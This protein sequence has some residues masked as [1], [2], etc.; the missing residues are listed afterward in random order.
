V[1]EPGKNAVT[2]VGRL[3]CSTNQY[4]HEDILLFNHVIIAVH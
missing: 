3:H 1:T 4:L 2:G